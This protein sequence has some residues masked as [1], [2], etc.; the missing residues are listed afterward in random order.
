MNFNDFDVLGKFIEK[1]FNIKYIGL[2]RINYY[3]LFKIENEIP[4]FIKTNFKFD[5]TTSDEKK[6]GIIQLNDIQHEQISILNKINTTRKININET[7][8]LNETVIIES[9][10]W[11][12]GV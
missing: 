4:K 5:W 1:K 12:S 11:K 10:I 7:I 9:S 2:S 3:P 8:Y 6:K